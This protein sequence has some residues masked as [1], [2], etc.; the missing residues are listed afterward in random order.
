MLSTASSLYKRNKS[1]YRFVA[2]YNPCIYNSSLIHGKREYTSRMSEQSEF[3][4]PHKLPSDLESNDSTRAAEKHKGMGTYSLERLSKVEFWSMLERV[5]VCCKLCREDYRQFRPWV[6]EC[7]LSV[8]ME[9][10]WGDCR[11]DASLRFELRCLWRS[12]WRCRRWDC[13][14]LASWDGR[15]SG[16]ERGQ[17]TV[18]ISAVG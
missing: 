7:E 17:R 13:V 4:A 15:C 12:L 2:E 16:M 5:Y 18:F 10:F 9:T 6:E 3:L 1:I 8:G 11:R 14:G